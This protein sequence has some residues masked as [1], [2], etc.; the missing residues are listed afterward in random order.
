MA[1]LLHERNQLIAEQLL[2]KMSS[3]TY[4]RLGSAGVFDGQAVELINGYV[5]NKM[6]KDPSHSHI[7]RLLVFILSRLLAGRDWIV[8]NQEPIALDESEPEPDIAILR[9]QISDYSRSH[10]TVDDV[11]LVIEVANSSLE[12]DSTLKK[13]LYAS[14]GISTYWIVNLRELRVEVHSDP[15]PVGEY[16]QRTIYLAKDELPVVIDGVE[17]GRI[18]LTDIFDSPL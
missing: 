6:P 5:V 12:V 17:F 10:P 7:T 8:S 11:D 16:R 15:V 4:H 13:A 1:T 2:W 3:E 14:A 18:A 9:G